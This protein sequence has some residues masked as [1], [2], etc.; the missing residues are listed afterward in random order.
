[1]SLNH[2]QIKSHPQ[3]ISNIKPFTDQY[4][5]K[6]TDFPSHIKDWKKFESN[7]KQLLLI[8]CMCLIILK[9]AKISK[10]NLDRENQI[11]LL[12]ITDCKK[13][14]YVAVKKLSVLLRGITLKHNGDF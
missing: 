6:E 1:M 7:N 11:I 4:N 8:F 12:R 2:E 13:W 9:H 3:R 10:Y 5:W 14:N